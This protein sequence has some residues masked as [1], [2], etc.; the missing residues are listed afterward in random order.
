VL[1]DLPGVRRSVEHDSVYHV[2]LFQGYLIVLSILILFMCVR[3]F[4]L[5][6]STCQII[7]I[8]IVHEVQ[9]KMH[10]NNKSEIKEIH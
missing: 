8:K 7:I 10:K 1:G 4:G 6:V 2:D 9:N 5:V 3:Y